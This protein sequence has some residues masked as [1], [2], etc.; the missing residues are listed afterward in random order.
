MGQRGV[1]PSG[2]GAFGLRQR[3]SSLSRRGDL[4]PWLAPK[5]P[6]PNCSSY[7]S[8]VYAAPLAGAV[9]SPYRARGLKPRALE[10]RTERTRYL[11]VP[12]SYRQHGARIY[13]LR[14]G[15][16]LLPPL[17]SPPH[18]VGGRANDSVARRERTEVRDGVAVDVP[19][20]PSSQPS[21][22]KGEGVSKSSICARAWYSDRD[23]RPPLRPRRT[24]RQGVVVDR[25]RHAGMTI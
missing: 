8:G 10:G 12:K 21:P 19:D 16:A 24:A 3:R 20:H 17:P 11:P 6:R 5:P 1:S 2:P 4:A 22:L 7:Y 18:G 23:S 15:I 25:L 14:S 9:S 13:S